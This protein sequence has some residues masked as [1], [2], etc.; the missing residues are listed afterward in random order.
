[1]TISLTSSHL[2]RSLLSLLLLSLLLLM[3][4]LLRWAQLGDAVALLALLLGLLLGQLLGFLFIL[5]L[6]DLLD[7]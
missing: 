1:M 4:L 2:L 5:E 7:S 3:L 6:V